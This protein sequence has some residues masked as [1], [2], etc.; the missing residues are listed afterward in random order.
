MS[1]KHLFFLVVFVASVTI[2]LG[3]WKIQKAPVNF[4][5]NDVFFVDSLYGWAVGDGMDVIATIDGGDSWKIIYTIPDTV[6]LKQVQFIDR[7]LGT[8]GGNIVKKYITHEAREVLI[9]RTTDGGF[10]WKKLNIPFDSSFSFVGIEFLN[11]DIGLVGINNNGQASW[12][13]RKGVMLKTVDGGVSWQIILEKKHLLCAAFVFFNDKQGYSFWSPFLSNYDD[14]FV[15]QTSDGGINWSDTGTIKEDLIKKTSSIT[16]NAIWAIGFKTWLSRDRGQSWTDWNWFSPVLEGQKRF[17][18]TDIELIDTNKIIIV[19]DAFS[20]S[21]DIE[22]RVY[23]TKDSGENWVMNLQLLNNSFS[24]ISLASNKVWVVGSNGLIIYTDDITTKV[25]SEKDSFPKIF[26]LE[27]NFPNPFNSITV[28]EYFLL[29]RADVTLK[30]FDVLGRTVKTISEPN[31]GLGRHIITWDGK[32]DENQP[33]ASGIYIYQLI[34]NNILEV[35]K[36]SL[37]R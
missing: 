31:L 22:A 12:N 24:A 1:K 6:E 5:L 19:G 17:I 25:A 37:I 7:N 32:N 21:S 29:Q 2:C 27:Q 11:S 26:E 23:T 28:V 10:T 14:T 36:M 15:L 18:P 16:F 13:E 34:S 30:I 8:I 9:M 20:S 33:V 4:R 3:Q 35:K